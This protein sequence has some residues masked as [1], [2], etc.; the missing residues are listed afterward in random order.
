MTIV[1]LHLKLHTQKILNLYDKINQVCTG[2]TFILYNFNYNR[3]VQVHVE[4]KYIQIVL[5]TLH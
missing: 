4:Q 1:M 2:K 3:M 5:N